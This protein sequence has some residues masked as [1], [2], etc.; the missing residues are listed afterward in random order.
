MKNLRSRLRLSLFSLLLVTTLVAVAIAFWSRSAKRQ[1]MLVEGILASGG[2]VAYDWQIDIATH[3]FKANPSSAYPKW[4]LDLLGEHYFHSVVFAQLNASKCKTADMSFLSYGD[5]LDELSIYGG[6][7]AG[8]F[9]T[10]YLPNLK[11]LD[12]MDD[13][14]PVT[15]SFLS[16]LTSL[17]HVSLGASRMDGLLALKDLPRLKH[18]YLRTAEFGSPEDL[19][20]LKQI[21]TLDI[22]SL[23][24]E[25]L[26]VLSEEQLAKLKE[27]LPRCNIGTAP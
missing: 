14:I 8:L 6:D 4:A 1:Q 5:S 24:P 21:E 20:E 13:S 17:E 7:P 25:L 22:H 3:D 19:A 16:R 26:P 27:S 10:A 23:H 15:F 12:V 2:N 9:D 11:R 18:V